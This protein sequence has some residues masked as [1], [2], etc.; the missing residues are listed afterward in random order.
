MV[1]PQIQQ[2]DRSG[3]AVW[4]WD[5]RRHLSLDETGHWWRFVLAN[6]HP[7]PGQGDA[8]DAIHLNSIEPWGRS[9]LVI[10]VRHTDAVYGID[11]R[12]GRILFKLGGVPT[13]E[14]LRVVGE[15][16]PPRKLFGGPHD[17]RVG[18]GGRLSVY[19]DGTHQA[20]PPRLARYDLDLRRADSHIRRPA[21]RPP[22]AGQSLLWLGAAV[23]RAAG[24]STGGTPMWSPASTATGGSVSACASPPRPSGRFRFPR[25][26][27]TA[28]ALDRFLDRASRCPTAVVD[29]SRGDSHIPGLTEVADPL[30]SA[31]APL[32]LSCVECQAA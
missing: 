30:S 31:A 10:A 13:R 9:R 11:R 26:A 6:P 14:S 1:F 28:A 15:P 23:R 5:S 8:Y 2:V 22:G 16:G 32:A 17:A 27:V 29:L 3:R 21:L 18:P 24:W 25:G 20:R 19:D 12:S 7:A 4:S